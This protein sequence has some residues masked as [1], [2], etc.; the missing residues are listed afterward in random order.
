[1][2][3]N[4]TIDM[5][6]SDDYK[7]RFKAEYHQTNIRYKKLLNMIKKAEEGT[8]DLTPECP[9]KLLKRQA[10]VMSEYLTVLDRRAMIEGVD[11]SV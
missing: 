5:M 8:L 7:E 4:E 2:D 10:N 1:M 9:L 6:T 3:L 11:L